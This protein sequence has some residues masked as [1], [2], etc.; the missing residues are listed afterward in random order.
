MMLGIRIALGG[1]GASDPHNNNNNNNETVRARTT[2]L[3]SERRSGES[4]RAATLPSR[5]TFRLN[6]RVKVSA[7]S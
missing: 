4:P 3:P 5:P 1:G 6:M 2:P 7:N